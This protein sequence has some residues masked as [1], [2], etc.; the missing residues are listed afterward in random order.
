[1][2]YFYSM[3]ESIYFQDFQVDSKDCSFQHEIKLPDI[4]GYMQEA[5]WSNADKLGFSTLELLKKDI[6]WVMNRMKLT[7][8]ELP[9]YNEHIKIETWPSGL[10]TLIAKRDFR[11][12]GKTGEVLVEATSNWLLMN[13][14]ERKLI[15]IPDYMKEAGFVVDRNNLS[16]ISEKIKYDSGLTQNTI[17]VSASWFDLDMNNHVNN[18]KYYQWLLDSL[19]GEFLASNQLVE[20]DIIFKQESNCGEMFESK[21][22]YNQ[23]EKCFYH[24][25]NNTST[26]QC[27]VLAKSIFQLR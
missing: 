14:N 20:M 6:T 8:Y 19:G 18:T 15:K 10:D 5:A 4:I 9:R 7:V 1:L 2:I 23:S 27:H 17:S 22:Y 3:D 16:E 24:T 26:D 21:S 12:W 25:L 13:I 11:V